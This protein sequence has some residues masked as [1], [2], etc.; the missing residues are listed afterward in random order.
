MGKGRRF[1]GEVLVRGNEVGGAKEG[2]RKEVAGSPGTS[3]GG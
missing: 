1:V 3:K 2:P